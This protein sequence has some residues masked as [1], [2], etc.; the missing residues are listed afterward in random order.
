MSFSDVFPEAHAQGSFCPVPRGA[1]GRI[2]VGMA[3]GT[4]GG[5]RI[6]PR[7]LIFSAPFLQTVGGRVFA[8]KFRPMSSH[9]YSSCECSLRVRSSL[10]LE[11][12]V[13]GGM[14][15]PDE[16]TPRWGGAGGEG[17]PPPPLGHVM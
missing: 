15:R 3:V 9:I 6:F 5:R 4:V 1:V 14:C 8:H 16:F 10:R 2:G 7:G 13:K 11:Y 17:A 12:F